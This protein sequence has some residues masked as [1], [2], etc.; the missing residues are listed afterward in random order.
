MRHLWGE[1]WRCEGMGAIGHREVV[2]REKKSPAVVEDRVIYI[3]IFHR[4][5]FEHIHV[6]GVKNYGGSGGALPWCVGACGS[7]ARAVGVKTC[8]VWAVDVCEG[9]ER[10]PGRTGVPKKESPCGFSAGASVQRLR[11]QTEPSMEFHG[12]VFQWASEL[13]LSRKVDGMI[14]AG[15]AQRSEPC[16]GAVRQAA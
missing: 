13:C 9:R 8:G 15:L 1:V 16:P 14:L 11:G 4:F 7:W 5:P 10:G 6:Y 3:N 12:L 2:V